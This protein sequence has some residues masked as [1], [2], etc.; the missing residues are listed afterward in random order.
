ML[1]YDITKHNSFIN[2][3]KWMCEL[4]EYAEP[5]I[6]TLLVGNK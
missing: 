5:S 4:Q 2:I 3:E 6:V 1:I